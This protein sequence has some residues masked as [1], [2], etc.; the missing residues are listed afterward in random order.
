ME[1]WD[2]LNVKP[3]FAKFMTDYRFI[4]IHASLTISKKAGDTFSK[5]RFY[6]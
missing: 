6:I 5:T 3:R 2:W 1:A 4:D